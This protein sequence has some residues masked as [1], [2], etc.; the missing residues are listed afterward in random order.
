MDETA[1]IAGEIQRWLPD[2]VRGTP[3]FWGAW[4]GRPYD[5]LLT[6]L[7]CEY[8]D[9]VLK[10]HFDRGEVLTVW[11]PKGLVLGHAQFQILEADRVRW[12]WFAGRPKAPVQR[13]FFDFV[14]TGESVSASAN[15]DWYTPD[16][17]TDLS[18]PA[19]EILVIESFRIRS[20]EA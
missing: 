13:Y 19:V 1:R 5:A 10:G 15:V 20:P 14:R 16:L 8:E 11:S 12:E 6:L 17:R 2:L 4:F 9:N 18:L 7:K 3:R